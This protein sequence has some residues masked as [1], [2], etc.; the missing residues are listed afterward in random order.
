MRMRRNGIECAKIVFVFVGAFH[1]FIVIAT[2]KI[3]IALNQVEFGEWAATLYLASRLRFWIWWWWL[4]KRCD[5]ID[6]HLRVRNSRR[7][8]A[9]ESKTRTRIIYLFCHLIKISKRSSIFCDLS[10]GFPE[11]FAIRRLKRNWL[12]K[13]SF[14]LIA[15]EWSYIYLM[16]VSWP[17]SNKDFDWES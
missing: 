6:K 3:I 8:C 16:K 4:I 10:N 11:W 1:T 5:A 9:R 12:I 17:F 13:Y 14:R 7:W 15:K 2:L